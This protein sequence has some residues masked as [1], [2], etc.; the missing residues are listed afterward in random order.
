MREDFLHSNRRLRAVCERLIACVTR[1]R[2][3]F[4]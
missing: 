2:A 1:D 3:M 4:A